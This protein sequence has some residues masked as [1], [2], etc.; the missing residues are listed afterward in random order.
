MSSSSPEALSYPKN[1]VKEPSGFSSTQSTVGVTERSDGPSLAGGSGV[2][3]VG[4]RAA[5]GEAVT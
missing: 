3:D 5:K 1:A 2:Y 4:Q